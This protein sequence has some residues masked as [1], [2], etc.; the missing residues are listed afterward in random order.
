MAQKKQAQEAEEQGVKGM[1]WDQRYNPT[2]A[3][4]KARADI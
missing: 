3:Q 1:K 4:I 2:Y